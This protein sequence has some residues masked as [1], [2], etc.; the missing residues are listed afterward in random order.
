MNLPKL[1][2]LEKKNKSEFFLSLVLRDEKASAVVFQEIDGKINVVGE[3]VVN[4]KTSVEEA[5]EDELL[6][7]IDKAVSTAEKNLP[8]DVESH[9]T[10]FGVKQ[11]WITDGKIKPEYLTKLKKVSDELEFKPMGFLVIPEAIAHLLQKEEGAPV[12]A[13]LAEIGHRN[14]TLSLIRAGKIIESKTSE[15]GESLV[16]TVETL[17]KHFSVESLPPRI[18][19]FDSGREDIQQKFITHKW[20]QSLHFFHLPQVSALPANF[21]ARAVLSGAATQMGFEIFEASLTDA[22]SANTKHIKAAIPIVEE[23][24]DRTLAEAASEFGFVGGDVKSSEEIPENQTNTKAETLEEEFSTNKPTDKEIPKTAVMDNISPADQFREIPEELKINSAEKK[25]F[26]VNGAF[27]MTGIMGF[28]K[29]VHPGKILK[30]ANGSRKK[31]A[32]GLIPLTII[33][34]FLYVYLFGRSVTVTLGIDAKEEDEEVNVTFSETEATNADD[35]IINAQFIT[36]TADG[37]KSIATT[38]KKEVGDKAKG[39]VT[40]FNSNTSGVTIPTG[41]VITSPNDL[42]FVTDKAVT[43]ASASGDIFSGTEPGKADVTVTAEKFGTSQNLPSNTKFTVDGSSSVAAK[44][45]KAFSGGTKKEVKVVA[46]K[47]QD[48]LAAELQKDLETEAK[49]QIQKEAED[50]S[51]VLPNFI[52]VEFDKKT[53]SKDIDDEATEISLTATISYRGVSYKE[54]DILNF[55]KDKLETGSDLVVDKDSVDASAANLKAK[56]NNATGK[57]TIKANLVPK[58]DSKE[59]A[60]EIKGKSAKDAIKK[61]NEINEINKVDIK[62]FPPIPFLPERIPFSSGKIKIMTEKN[63]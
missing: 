54:T 9:K 58:I 8:P 55:A 43:I 42:K 21:D 6:D 11:D 13:I 7:A 30:G 3:H 15:I 60:N 17:L 2:F 35:D 31:L 25:P 51:V 61:L 22:E 20:S 34:L 39:T 29:T 16:G 4:F 12:T 62:L 52:S 41:T 5:S 32:I 56:G 40:L 28:M 26:P 44:N 49:E 46:K 59:I 37:K 48:K 19:L 10:I 14:V 1:P 53:F 63:G 47:D 57:L 23:E 45:D 27:I 38:G 24:T 33:L 50:G 18:I 36:V